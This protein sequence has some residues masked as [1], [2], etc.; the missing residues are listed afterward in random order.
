MFAH[1]DAGPHNTDPTPGWSM[2]GEKVAARLCEAKRPDRL[3]K[4]RYC[5]FNRKPVSW[6]DQFFHARASNPQRLFSVDE[7]L[8]A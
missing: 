1:E 5:L 3:A 4:S 7:I 2:F 8:L 6:Q